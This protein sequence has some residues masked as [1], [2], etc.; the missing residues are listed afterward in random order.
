LI[1][2]AMVVVALPS[3]ARAQA[4]YGSI[5]GTIQDS[6]G[7]ALPGVNVIVTSNERKTTDTVVTNGSGNYVKDRLLPG[8]YSVKAELSGFKPTLL[9]SVK[10]DVDTQT[11][12]DLKLDVGQLTEAVEVTAAEG[13]LLKT[14]RADV[15]TTFDS[16]Q[17]S[18]LP[19]LDRNFTKLIL[20][21]PGTQQQSW[22]HAAS[23][24]PQGSLQTQ[25]NGQTFAG[26]GYQLDGTENR[27]P[28]L[29][30]I[31][32]NPSFEAI[33][34]TKIT[35]QNYDAE[36]GQAIAGVVS[37]QTKSGTN[38]M[39]GSLFEYLQRDKFRA[40][41]PFS[42]PDVVNPLTGRVLPQTKR[43]QFGG[44]I[45]G[46]IKKNE[47]F[48]F[49]DYQGTRSNQGGSKL[50]TVPTTLARTG[51]LT[52]Y[53][54]NIFDPAS[55]ATPSSRQQFAGNIIPGSRLSPQAQR[56][57]ALIPQ[58]NRPGIRDNFVAQGS[59]KFNNDSADVRLD[60]RLSSSLNTFVRYSYARFDLNGP[61]AFGTG[62]G[63]ELVSLG[64]NSKVRNHS[65]AAGID[66]TLNSQTVLDVRLGFFK[67]GVDV[68][69]FDFGTSPAKDAGI[70][71]LNLDNFSSGLPAIFLRGGLGADIN[72]GSGLGVNRCNC[73]LAEH[74]KQGQIVAN[75]TRLAGNHTVKF[76]IDIRR[77]YNLRVPSDSHRSGELTFN[78]QN[79]AGPNGGGLGIATFLL[80][81]VSNMRRY[82][83]PNTNARERQWRQFYYVQ[84]TWRA[85]SKVTLN[86]GLRADIINPQTVNE[87][88]NGGWLDITTGEIRVGGMVPDQPQDRH[89]RR[90]RPQLRHRRVRVDVRPQRHAE[91]ARPGRSGPA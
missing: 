12:V 47:W 70:P 66:Y 59:E 28:I 35:S 76:G 62:G 54:V 4:V 49:A 27:D 11:K 7:A 74:E 5:A 72:F 13:Q 42:E 41:N 86:Y 51:N 61:T 3:V 15:S 25:V 63:S 69:P 23:E 55:G 56:I 16:K 91:P 20:L 31:V 33:G 9:S 53:G 83:S 57:L 38:D 44:S 46:P 88:G 40:R 50:L 26:T 2:V 64:G 67:Y 81:N 8:T 37:V 90:L 73:P 10:V 65:V 19:I 77:A 68:L 79:T 24:N 84:D 52:E 1:A 48:F 30:I 87:A 60:G 89:S 71:G 17:I 85:T 29:G 36:F 75:L 18:D 82:V 14:D 45:G 34:E 43:D 58:P 80:G 78:E 22:N 6:T 39:H 32:I 21:T